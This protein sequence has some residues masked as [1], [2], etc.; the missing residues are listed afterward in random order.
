MWN[1]LVAMLMT[2]VALAQPQPPVRPIEVSNAMGFVIQKGTERDLTVSQ[3]TRGWAV[4]DGE[5]KF[6]PEELANRNVDAKLRI[7]RFAPGDDTV[8]VKV[9]M[10]PEQRGAEFWK[11][12]EGADKKKAVVLV[13]T[14]GRKYEAVG[15]IYRDPKIVHLRFTRGT[16]LKGMAEAPSVSR[17]TPDRE[18]TLVFVVSLG[19]EIKELRIGDVVVETYEP[20]VKCDQ[21]QK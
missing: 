10:T 7:D 11:K 9:N 8:I 13:D 12:V 19:V 4:R 14:K 6:K 5:Q 21:K 3:E 18:L 2:V 16:P 15:F 17:T 20:A 1:A